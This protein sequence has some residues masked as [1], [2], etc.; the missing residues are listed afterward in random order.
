[1]Q[2]ITRPRLAIQKTRQ[3]GK[4]LCMNLWKRTPS[5][6]TR[7][8]VKYQYFRW[9]IRIFVESSLAKLFMFLTIYGS[10][11]NKNIYTKKKL[12][13]RWIFDSRSSN[14]PL[15]HQ[16]YYSASTR[17]SLQILVFASTTNL[18]SGLSFADIWV[19]LI[20]PKFDPP[21]SS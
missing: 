10:W 11:S 21:P 19:K 1:M 16:F 7:P 15:I 6:L 4:Y 14:S 3:F 20:L 8:K 17:L 18:K 9:M 2:R 5:Y 12:D 13:I